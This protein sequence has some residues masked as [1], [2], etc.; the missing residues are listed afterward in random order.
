MVQCSVV[1][2]QVALKIPNHHVGVTAE[3]LVLFFFSPDIRE[4]RIIIILQTARLHR[5]Y[6]FVIVPT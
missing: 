6:M 3:L 5:F 4:T 2:S 1:Y